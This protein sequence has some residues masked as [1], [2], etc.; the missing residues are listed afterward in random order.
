MLDGRRSCGAKIFN[1][2]AGEYFI[3]GDNMAS[4]MYAKLLPD[5]GDLDNKTGTCPGYRVYILENDGGVS[6]QMMH[7]S[8]DPSSGKSESVF[9]NVEEAE[10]L[11]NGLQEAIDRA[12]PKKAG[13]PSR[14]KNC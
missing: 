7:P 8:E 13:H 14:A 6:L 3:Q 1:I 4:L 9:L 11:L 12:K 5:Y 2:G 10:E